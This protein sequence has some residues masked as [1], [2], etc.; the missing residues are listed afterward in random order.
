M[1]IHVKIHPDSSKDEV[2]EKSDVSFI[3]HVRAPAER[4]EAN[5]RM[6]QVL[7]NHLGIPQEKLRIVTGHHSPS[8]ILEIL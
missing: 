5:V 7:A 6:R 2:I 3:V 4:N 1:L 8:K